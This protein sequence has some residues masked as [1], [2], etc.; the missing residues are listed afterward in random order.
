MSIRLSSDEIYGK[1]C[2]PSK[3]EVKK[4]KSFFNFLKGIAG[5]KEKK[6]DA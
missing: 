4:K 6:N 5:K 1:K 2:T 3:E